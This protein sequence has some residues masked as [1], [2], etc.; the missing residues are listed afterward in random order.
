MNHLQLP[1]QKTLFNTVVHPDSAIKFAAP[2]QLQPVL[3]SCSSPCWLL[4]LLPRNA[5]STAGNSMV[6]QPNGKTKQRTAQLQPVVRWSSCPAVI[7]HSYS[8]YKSLKSS[9][10]PEQID[11]QVSSCLNSM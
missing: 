7:P 1:L 4:L 8:K 6:H 10:L 9:C 5:P 11:G 2:L 3:K